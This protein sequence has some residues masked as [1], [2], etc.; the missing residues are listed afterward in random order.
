MKYSIYK[1]CY[2]AFY[3]FILIIITQINK[4]FSSTDKL[5][6]SFLTKTIT[7]T[8]SNLQKTELN[9]IFSNSITSKNEKSLS[10]LTFQSKFKTQLKS[11]FSFG[12]KSL[13]DLKNLK[14]QNR[15][16]GFPKAK[17][18]LNNT[19]EIGKGPIYFEGWNKYFIIKNT[20]GFEMKEFFINGAYYKEQIEDF[21]KKHEEYSDNYISD[22]NQFYFIL[23]DEYLNVVSS[24]FVYFSFDLFFI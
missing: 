1:F 19:A 12:F 22:Q 2:L 17:I 4:T 15:F 16:Q 8:N 23:T 24:K 13:F 11:L 20:K 6:N 5:K 21:K 7:N 10:S 3:F 9:S 14:I 18:D